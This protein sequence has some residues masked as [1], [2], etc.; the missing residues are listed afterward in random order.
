MILIESGVPVREVV[1]VTP[2]A[3]NPNPRV[4]TFLFG[5]SY[6][7]VVIPVFLGLTVILTSALW[8]NPWVP[9]KETFTLFCSIDPLIISLL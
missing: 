7:T 9:A 8:P 1:D 3:A 5:L 4:I 6:C 2:L